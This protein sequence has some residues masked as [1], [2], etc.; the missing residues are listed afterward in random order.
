M[1]RASCLATFTTRTDSPPDRKS[2]V[3]LRFVGDDLDPAKISAVLSI[4]PTRAHKK[5]E[6]FFAGKRTGNLRGRSGIWYLAT[7]KLVPSDNLLDH[8][9]LV[10]QLLC[11]SPRDNHIVLQLRDILQKSHAGAHLTCF[12]RGDPGE[13]APQIPRGFRSALAPLSVDIETDFASSSQDSTTERPASLD[14]PSD[15]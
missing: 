7:D 5:G 6:E 1:T 9:Q 14:R 8:L 4:D 13:A 12:W 11:P 3:T 10:Q 15:F 2:F